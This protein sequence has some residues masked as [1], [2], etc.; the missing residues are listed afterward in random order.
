MQARR[1]QGV[2]PPVKGTR[3]GFGVKYRLMRFLSSSGKLPDAPRESRKVATFA[4]GNHRLGR[5]HVEKAAIATFG[6]AQVRGNPAG[7]FRDLC[8]ACTLVQ[9]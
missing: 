4:R 7:C 3:P 5:F 8:P 9:S 2:G 6:R 1:H